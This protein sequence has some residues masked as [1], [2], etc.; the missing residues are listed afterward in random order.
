MGVVPVDQA[1]LMGGTVREG[2]S[3][4][5]AN[6]SRCRYGKRRHWMADPA[7]LDAGPSADP[8]SSPA[9]AEGPIGPREAGH[10]TR[11]FLVRAEAEGWV[12]DMLPGKPTGRCQRVCVFRYADDMCR[13]VPLSRTG[14]AP[15]Q[16][17]QWRA[18]CSPGQRAHS[19]GRPSSA[20][21]LTCPDSSGGSTGGGADEPSVVS[22]AR[23][24]RR[25][26]ATGEQEHGEDHREQG[27]QPVAGLKW[28]I[29]NSFVL[30]S[31]ECGVIGPYPVFDTPAIWHRLVAW[32]HA[33]VS[34]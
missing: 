1:R 10:R 6:D 4:I 27:E 25:T 8:G 7:P 24:G 33:R 23:P 20:A 22:R 14:G 16:V 15:G 34:C 19:H 9:T 18:S 11:C 12:R 32:G 13:P 28:I 5:P 29:A 26:K 31:R 2:H 21:P 17:G 30:R 3:G